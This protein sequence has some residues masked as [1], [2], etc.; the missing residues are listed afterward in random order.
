MSIDFPFQ[1]DFR[2]NQFVEA[3]NVTRVFADLRSS[4]D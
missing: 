1:S 4:E 2:D 3:N